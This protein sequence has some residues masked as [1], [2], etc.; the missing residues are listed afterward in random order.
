M[1]GTLN[2]KVARRLGVRRFDVAEYLNSEADIA[3]YLEAVLAEDDPRL[4]AAALGEVARARGMTQLARETGLSREA[5]YRALS[6][7]GNPELATVTK[8]L[9]AL[10]L[11]LSIQPAIA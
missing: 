7:E 9:R 8:V 11:R 6:S 1:S 3:A 10:G 5:L 2:A 4:L